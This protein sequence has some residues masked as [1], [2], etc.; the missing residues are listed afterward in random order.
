MVVEQRL[1][2]PVLLSPPRHVDLIEYVL[3]DTTKVQGFHYPAPRTDSLRSDPS[4]QQ[5]QLRPLIET[6]WPHLARHNQNSTFQLSTSRHRASRAIPPCHLPET[7]K[8][9]D[10]D[11]GRQSRV[12]RVFRTSA[13]LLVQRDYG[14]SSGSRE[15]E[16]RNLYLSV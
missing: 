13:S 6:L 11:R 3:R 2:P 7:S 9:S 8:L 10:Q 12:G 15:R 16:C 5:P 4:R 1:L 14:L